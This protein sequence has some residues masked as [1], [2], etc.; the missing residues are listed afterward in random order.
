MANISVTRLRPLHELRPN[1][2]KILCEGTRQKGRTEATP[3]KGQ[4]AQ[5]PT[6]SRKH[7]AWRTHKREEAS[8]G[9]SIR[10]LPTPTKVKGRLNLKGSS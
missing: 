1:T 8:E 7:L 5:T 2:G 6:P 10:S 3:G 9:Q 4:K